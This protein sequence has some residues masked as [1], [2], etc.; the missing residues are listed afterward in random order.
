MKPIFYILGFFVLLAVLHVV[1]VALFAFAAEWIPRLFSGLSDLLAA[2]SKLSGRDVPKVVA[3]PPL[4]P[5][6]AGHGQ[7]DPPAPRVVPPP[8][9]TAR[10]LELNVAM[11][12]KVGIAQCLLIKVRGGPVLSNSLKVV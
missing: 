2:F 9:M 5:L 11:G 8:R 4:P 6:A 7:A 3:P 12:P 1:V 10:K